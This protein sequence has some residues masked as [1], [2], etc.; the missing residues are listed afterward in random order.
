MMRAIEIHLTPDFRGTRRV[1]LRELDGDF[2]DI[3]FSEQVAEP[4]WPAATFDRN[5]P[6]PLDEIRRA[7]ERHE[8][9]PVEDRAPK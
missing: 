7:V 2:T 9:A 1:V 5:K 4:P 3:R 6:A 8:A